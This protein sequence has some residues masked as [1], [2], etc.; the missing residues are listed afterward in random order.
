M[1]AHPVTL[2]NLA[3]W[4][5]GTIELEARRVVESHLEG[6]CAQ[7]TA[8]LAWLRRFQAAARAEP[9]PE[10]PAEWTV[11]VKALY[12]RRPARPSSVWP[13]R[14]FL[15]RR[16]VA[17]IGA[18]LLALVGFVAWA[19]FWEQ[20][21]TAVA[22]AAGT[23][24][25]SAVVEV[26]EAEEMPW[27][28][29]A[30]VQRLAADNWVR[31]GQ[32]R[33]VIRLFDGSLL[34]LEAGSEVHLVSLKHQPLVPGRRQVVI[35]QSAG[36]SV[37]DV[38]PVP[39]QWGIFQ[40]E[41][42]GGT[43]TVR[44][45]RF[46]VQVHDQEQTR[47][48]VME[49]R[50]EVAGQKNQAELSASQEAILRNGEVQVVMP[51]AHPTPPALR[52]A[53]PGLSPIPT[54]EGTPMPSRSKERGRT[55]SAPTVPAGSPTVGRPRPWGSPTLGGDV[56]PTSAAATRPMR[57][58][59]PSRTPVP[60]PTMSPMP[61]RP[62]ER[63]RTPMPW[64]TWTLGPAPTRER[65]PAPWVT[66]TRRHGASPQPTSWPAP[67]MGRPTSESTPVP[68]P[69]PPPTAERGAFPTPGSPRR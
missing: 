19:L 52:T 64:P 16:W 32:G 39:R 41:V 14:L 53:A 49:G 35:A 25:A 23:G 27:R 31:V 3:D 5:D 51:D 36:T 63:T 62:A 50:V 34:Q 69:S 24:T 55:G 58:P 6:G 66:P 1:N 57:T 30:E 4:L 59:A 47:V 20:E 28:P 40:V 42:P 18:F 60:A 15:P 8:E 46:Q 54:R 12:D 29:A 10:P 17:V 11:R 26:R 44:G 2:E 48:W 56:S 38:R 45:T 61:T 65:T 43:I 21:E 9:L 22:L 68:W 33:A 67:T 13:A 37:Y 7:C